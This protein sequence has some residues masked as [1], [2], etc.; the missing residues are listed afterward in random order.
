MV[1]R[2]RFRLNLVIRTDPPAHSS[3]SDEPSSRPSAARRWPPWP[4]SSPKQLAD[5]DDEDEDE[6][7]DAAGEPHGASGAAVLRWSWPPPPPPLF[8]LVPAAAADDVVLL[9]EK[10]PTPALGVLRNAAKPLA[11]LLGGLLPPPAQP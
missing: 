4:W 6:A 5:R 8:L 2:L 1:G 10:R 3:S 7:D 11:V 9:R